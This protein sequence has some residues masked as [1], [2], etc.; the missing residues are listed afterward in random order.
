MRRKILFLVVLAMSSWELQAIPVFARQ[1]NVSC[2]TCHVA[3]PRL[4]SFG[5]YFVAQNYRLPQAKETSVMDVG[6]EKLQLQKQFPLAVRM[7]A[8][9][10][11][12]DSAPVNKGNREKTA[13]ADIQAP[14]MIKL[15]S[16]APINEHISYYFYA[17]LAEKG[18]NGTVIVEDAW[19]GF[20][21][22]LG[23]GVGMTIGQFQI[24]DLMFPREQRLTFQDFIL[25]RTSNITYDRGAFLSYDIKFVSLEAGISNGNGIEQNISINGPGYKRP[26]HLFDNDT[27]KT[28]FGRIGFDLELAELGLFGLYRENK[29]ITETRLSKQAVAGVD[30]SGNIAGS[31]YWFSQFLYHR[32]NNFLSP[33]SKDEWW[34]AFLGVDYKFT[35][36]WV[37]SILYNYADAKD[38]KNSN[39]EYKGLAVNSLS[40]GFSYYV[41]RNFKATLEGGIDF[42]PIDRQ[43]VYGH[44]TQENYV[45]FGFD[46]AM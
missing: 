43:G 25:Y 20:S 18:G 46:F 15:L 5:Q 32:W 40:L 17:I 31:F 13:N 44:K 37:F 29:D 11:A 21:D 3:F 2:Q 1:Y 14:Y 22:L 39:T 8:Y 36:D 28:G 6:D 19:I 24:S 16:S 7:M 12:R 33:G 30:L 4:N 42:L 10:Q 45:V 9:L 41:M 35:E 27:G 26:D 23:S 34:G 38:F